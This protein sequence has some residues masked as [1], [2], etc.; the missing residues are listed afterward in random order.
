M[1]LLVSAPCANRPIDIVSGREVNAAVPTTGVERRGEERRMRRRAVWRTLFGVLVSGLLLISAATPASAYGKE[2]WQIGVAGTAT[3][4]GTGVGFGFWG[5]C[6]FGSG[7]VTSGTDGDCQ[8]ADYF[9]APGGAGATCHR[10]I[11]VT[12]WAIQ[13]DTQPGSLPVPTFIISGTATSRPATPAC[14]QTFPASFSGFDT[15]FPGA[16]GHYNLTS[17]FI[18]PGFVGELQIQVTQIP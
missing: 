16:P 18:P 10:S 2:I 11:D 5:W 3:Q 4:P 13:Q 17:V 9:H 1:T 14:L 12:S 6:A 15:M 7:S 8:I